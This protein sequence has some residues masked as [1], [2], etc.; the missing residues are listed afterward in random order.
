MSKLLDS[1]K[2]QQS[3]ANLN[4][5][6]TA[7]TTA[8]NQG[9]P[10]IRVNTLGMPQA[11]PSKWKVYFPSGTKARDAGVGICTLLKGKDGAVFANEGEEL[12]ATI[13]DCN[14]VVQERVFDKGFARFKSDDPAAMAQAEKKG[15]VTANGV[16]Y[17]TAAIRHDYQLLFK[18]PEGGDP[19]NYPHN[20]GG[21]NYAVVRYE[22][23]NDE[24]GDNL[25]VQHASLPEVKGNQDAQLCIG[26]TF[27]MTVASQPPVGKQQQPRCFLKASGGYG[28]IPTPTAVLQWMA[29]DGCAEATLMLQKEAA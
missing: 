20:I 17:A 8:P 22:T 19:S 4:A 21:D 26:M 1:I 12:I 18:M 5:G 2:A 14:P 15:L 11:K 9:A 29:A 24:Q 27:K 16:N 28:E 3:A 6:A 10:A 13:R 23:E 25:F 7:S